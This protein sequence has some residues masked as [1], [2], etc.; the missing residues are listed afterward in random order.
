MVD[1]WGVRR[2]ISWRTVRPPTPESK[3]PI[4]RGSDTGV[5]AT[6][7][8]RR[9]PRAVEDLAGDPDDVL[10]DRRARVGQDERHALVVRADDELAARHD[11][12]LRDPPK[13][14]MQVARVDAAGAIDAV[15]EV[16]DL[17]RRV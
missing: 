9:H 8:H 4:G 11:L 10:A 2:R 14:P 17:R 6:A 3:T 5:L 7:G 12:V 1:S 15:D 16:A 13:R